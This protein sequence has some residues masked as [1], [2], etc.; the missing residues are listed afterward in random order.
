M[1][2]LNLLHHVV[3]GVYYLD[4]ISSIYSLLS[5]E[6]AR[7]FVKSHINRGGTSPLLEQDLDVVP[8]WIC[9]NKQVT[10]HK[11]GKIKHNVKTYSIKTRV[12]YKHRSDFG[13]DFLEFPSLG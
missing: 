4:F 6:D 2:H 1:P 13:S 3:A 8:A 7:L 10:R 12:R 5:G 11:N 9:L